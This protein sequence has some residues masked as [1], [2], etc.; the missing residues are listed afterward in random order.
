MSDK[1]SHSA[2]FIDAN[3]QGA[4]KRREVVASRQLRD[5]IGMLGQVEHDARRG[6]MTED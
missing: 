2:L 5:G 4:T 1:S 3:E 6:A